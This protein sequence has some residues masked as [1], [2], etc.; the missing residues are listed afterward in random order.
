MIFEFSY[1]GETF[2]YDDE[3]L[4]IP[5]ARFAKRE[6]GMSGLR[7]F[8]AAQELDADCL[9]ALLVMAMRRKGKTVDPEDIYRGDDNGYFKLITNLSVRD[10][11]ADEASTEAEP[12]E[13][14]PEPVSEP[15]A[16]EE[17]PK[18]T[19]AKRK[20]E[21]VELPAEPEQDL[22]AG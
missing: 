16:V 11:A 10:G 15:E 22:Q 14:E 1:F 5:E 8:N 3:Q 2:D 12:V 6:T 17:R 21:M 7:F 13:P 20:I 19:R 18:R 9:V 4:S